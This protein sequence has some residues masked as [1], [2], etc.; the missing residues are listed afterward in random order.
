ME[1]VYAA[2]AQESADRAAAAAAERAREA[3]ARSARTGCVDFTMALTP[4][5]IVRQDDKMLLPPSALADLDRLGGTGTSP[6]L[7]EL[8][9]GARKALAGVAEF[10]AQ[11]GEVGVPPKVA[12]ALALTADAAQ[13]VEVSYVLLP[14]CPRAQA[15]IEPTGE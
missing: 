9:C 14:V 5:P 15:S 3:E 6:L 7:F 10:T 4:V 11:E 13:K 12:L 1:K 8:T 2:Q